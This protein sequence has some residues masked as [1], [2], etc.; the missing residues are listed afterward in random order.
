MGNNDRNF[1]LILAGGK[2]RRLWPVSNRL[3]PKQFLDFFSTGRT[4]LQTTY[5][6]ALRIVPR[7]NIFIS[8]NKTY[9]DIVKEQ[10]PDAITDNILLEPIVRNTA[11]SVAWATFRIYNNPELNGDGRLLVIPSDQAIINEDEYVESANAIFDYAATH[12]KL[13]LVGVVPTRPEQGY[14]Y[15][16]MDGAAPG[17]G[18]RFFNAKTFVEK[19]SLEYAQMFLE[20]GEFLWNTG[21]V[22][23]DARVFRTAFMKVFPYVFRRMERRHEF[24]ALEREREYVSAKYSQLPNTSIEKSLF[25]DCSN[26]VVM[27]ASF[28]WAD[29]G[30]WHSIYS[31]YAEEG[32]DNV[33]LNSKVMFEDSH[34]NIV[35]LPDDRVAVIANLNGYIVT[36]KNGV[37]MICKKENSSSLIKKY[38]N[39]VRIIYGEEYL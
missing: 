5:E 25:E 28:G 26:H 30:S 32:V 27:K 21:M 18:D 34:G 33:V 14:G 35:N 11:P 13:V 8:T 9:E 15:F 36:E 10:I 37:L 19:P 31:Q 3:L 1:I 2:G 24:Y 7:E 22:C 12:D 16:Q 17:G 39:E 38:R 6:R 4:Q 20:T 23:A 29:I